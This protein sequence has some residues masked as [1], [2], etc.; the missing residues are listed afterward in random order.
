MELGDLALHAASAIAAFFQSVT[1]IGFGMVA[2]PV[3]LVVLEDPAAVIITSLLTWLIALVLL[4]LLW[5]DI[6]MRMAARLLAGAVLGLPAGLALLAV[7]DIATLKLV[8]GLL[9]ALLTGVIL[10]G[11]PGMSRPG[12]AGDMIFGG[13]GG[14]FGACIAIPGPT[15]AVRL[16]GLGNPKTTV[17]ATMVGFFAV[18]TPLIVLGQSAS[19]GVSSATLWNALT[20]MPATLAGLAIGNY[21]AARVSEQFFRRLVIFFLFATSASLLGNAIWEFTLRGGS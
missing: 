15:A 4:P 10:F 11:A 21:A 16:S 17:R 5:R 13:L 6:D 2:G 12:L 18:I 3:I 14:V 8:A 1:G 19:I 20:L 7:A 9:I